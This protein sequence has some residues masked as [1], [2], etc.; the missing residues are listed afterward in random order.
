MRIYG[1]A[2]IGILA[3]CPLAAHAETKTVSWYMS[4]PDVRARV[5]KLCMNNPGEA[6]RNADCINAE[7]ASE[8]ASLDKMEAEMDR[9]TMKCVP[10]SPL[11]LMADKCTPISKAH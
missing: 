5:N 7:V 6:R 10:S 2:I 8:H 11:M 1:L 4:H 9:P 3:V